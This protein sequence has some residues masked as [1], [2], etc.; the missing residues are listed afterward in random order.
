MVENKVNKAVKS[1]IGNGLKLNKTK[2]SQGLLDP[3]LALGFMLI[4]MRYTFNHIVCG[5]AP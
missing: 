4:K 5:R 2:C 3:P 1:V